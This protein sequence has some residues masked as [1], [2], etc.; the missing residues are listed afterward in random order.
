MLTFQALRNTITDPDELLPL[1]L[2]KIDDSI[3]TVFRQVAMNRF[4]HRIHTHRRERGELEARDFNEHWLATQQDMFGDA[5]QISLD[6]THWWSYIPHFLH[7]P[8]YVYAYAFGELLVLS[9][10]A[11]YQ[12]MG[13][14]FANLYLELLEAGG[15]N[16]PHELLK[17]FGIDLNESSFWQEGLAGVEQM[18]DEAEKL[19]G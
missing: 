15:S 13:S 14:S 9:L 19:A 16:Y 18:I 4:E 7:T 11:K 2:S 6:Y 1:L 10:Y 5:C 8:G 3:A 12:T 17:P